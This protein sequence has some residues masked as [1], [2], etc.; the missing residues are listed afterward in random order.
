MILAADW[1]VGQFFIALIWLVLFVIWVWLAIG[2]FTDI[3]HSPDLNGIAKALW[4][5]FI[6]VAPYIG[7]L[8]YLIARGQKMTE[9]TLA[10]E[11]RRESAFRTY[12]Q[13]AAGGHSALDDL[14][15]LDSLHQHGVIDDAEFARLKAKV[16]V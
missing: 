16:V 10:F 5:V 15:R 3:F 2:V 14:E 4:V 11:R 1:G 7:V 9:H 12:V 8:L 6:V 13:E